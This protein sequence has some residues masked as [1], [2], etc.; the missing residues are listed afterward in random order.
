M[1]YEKDIY[2]IPNKVIKKKEN[3][4]DLNQ[5]LKSSTRGRTGEI[6]YPSLTIQITALQLNVKTAQ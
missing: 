5:I 6:K 4:D 2:F 3:I 1:L